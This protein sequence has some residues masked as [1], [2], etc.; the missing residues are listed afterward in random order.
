MCRTAAPAAPV[1][2]GRTGG[3]AGLGSIKL[4]LVI[5]FV[6]S[7]SIVLGV[8]ASGGGRLKTVVVVSN[9]TPPSPYNYSAMLPKGGAIPPSG[10]SPGNNRNAAPRLA[11]P[12]PP[13]S[14][15]QH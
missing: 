5:W 8:D 15:K 12:D 4:L 14:M 1:A 13:P 11:S 9:N 6:V 3:V 7:I 10:P 2:E